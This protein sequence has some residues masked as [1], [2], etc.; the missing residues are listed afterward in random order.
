MIVAFVLSFCFK[1]RKTSRNNMKLIQLHAG[2][3]KL[4]GITMKKDKRRWFLCLGEVEMKHTLLT[5][6]KPTEMEKGI[7][8]W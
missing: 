6:Q 8:K 2:V 1:T 4:R 5:V 3:W 7:F